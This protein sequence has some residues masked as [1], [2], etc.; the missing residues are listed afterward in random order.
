MENNSGDTWGT[1]GDQRP[2]GHPQIVPGGG[3]PT[4]SAITRRTLLAYSAG[5]FLSSSEGLYTG[6]N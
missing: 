2:S 3:A 4:H 5:S 1:E 6:R